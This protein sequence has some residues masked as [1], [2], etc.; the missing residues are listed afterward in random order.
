MGALIKTASWG[1]NSL[2]VAVG[3]WACIFKRGSLGVVFWKNSLTLLALETER[4]LVWFQMQKYDFFSYPPN[5]AIKK[6][7]PIVIIYFPRKFLASFFLNETKKEDII[8]LI[9]PYIIVSQLFIVNLLFFARFPFVLLSSV[10]AIARTCRSKHLF[11]VKG[12]EWGGSG[13]QAFPYPSPTSP[14]CH[15]S[16]CHL[17]FSGSFL[18]R[19]VGGV[20][21]V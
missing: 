17:S 20:C 12:D 15:L 18:G 3:R 21:C 6:S 14:I 19:E 10:Q 9:I 13:R 2:A 7:G 16:F 1:G 5:L 11:T 8:L 4:F